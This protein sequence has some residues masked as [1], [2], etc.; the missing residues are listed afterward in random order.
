MPKKSKAARKARRAEDKSRK[1]RKRSSNRVLI[2]SKNMYT[3]KSPFSVD[4]E[5]ANEITFGQE[6][7][8]AR[9]MYGRNDYSIYQADPRN[10]NPTTIIYV[11]DPEVAK[12]RNASKLYRTLWK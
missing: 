7:L 6:I 2:P 5:I 12:K 3:P 11:V 8:P 9:N 1:T 4:P 10:M